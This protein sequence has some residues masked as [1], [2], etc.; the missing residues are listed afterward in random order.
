[1]SEN[2]HCK[3]SIPQRL[4]NKATSAFTQMQYG[5]KSATH[6]VENSSN[7]PLSFL[8]PTVVCQLGGST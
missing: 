2:E 3:I 8:N 6:A 1:M 5:C 7:S 4:F